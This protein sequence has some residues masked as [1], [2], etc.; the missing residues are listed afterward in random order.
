M[1]IPLEIQSTIE[2]LNTELIYIREQTQYGLT[3]LR[4]LLN[5]FPNNDLL[6]QFYGFLNNSL[7]LVDIYQRRIRF[8]VELLQQETLSEEEIQSK[9][10]LENIIRRL[11][12]II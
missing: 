5:S 2:R 8:V 4:P 11:E 7:F 10:V 1:S 3:I 9:I 12:A 6:T